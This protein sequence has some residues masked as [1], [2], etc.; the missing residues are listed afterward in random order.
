MTDST[1]FGPDAMTAV[2]GVQGDE[3]LVVFCPECGVDVVGGGH[4]M[5]GSG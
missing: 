4:P 5:C 1:V 3:V 2:A